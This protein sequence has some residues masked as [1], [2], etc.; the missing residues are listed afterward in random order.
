MRKV[1]RY[2]VVVHAAEEGGYWVEV[3]AL[4]GCYSQ[5]ESVDETLENVKE[6]MALYV[7]ALR[8]EGREVPKDEDVVFHVASQFEAL[9]ESW[10]LLR[11]P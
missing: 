1:M 9:C 3:P 8:E 10:A 4:R 2:S 7:E 5:G 6:A 11:T